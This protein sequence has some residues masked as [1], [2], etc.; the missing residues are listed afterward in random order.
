[1]SRPIPQFYEVAA[2]GTI[3]LF[4]QFVRPL[5][6]ALKKENIYEALSELEK[7][8]EEGNY[9]LETPYAT[10][11][12]RALRW[13][14]VLPPYASHDPIAFRDDVVQSITDN[15]LT[16]F[17]FQHFQIREQK[18]GKPKRLFLQAPPKYYCVRPGG[19]LEHRMQVYD[20]KVSPPAVCC[21]GIP[22][23]PAF[24]PPTGSSEHYKR[25]WVPLL[26]TWDGS[27]AINPFTK[28]CFG[29]FFATLRFVELAQ[30]MKWEGLLIKPMDAIGRPSIELRKLPWP[31]S[32]WYPN[33]QPD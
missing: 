7:R 20:M 21:D 16:G 10:I 14:A 8:K 4:Y 6:M 9:Y 3:R 31:P 33:D 15:G 26:E 32:L 17:Q 12:G 27:D 13:P 24:K 5:G 18:S 30:R 25:R 11:E 28:L 19:H 1:M 2:T 22:G 23:D 29:K